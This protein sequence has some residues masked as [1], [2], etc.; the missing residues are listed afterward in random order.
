MRED[1]LQC[2]PSSVRLF[3]YRLQATSFIYSTNI[4]SAPSVDRSCSRYWGESADGHRRGPYSPGAYLLEGI[5][6]G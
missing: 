1:G 3:L 6:S 4:C 2:L 5:G